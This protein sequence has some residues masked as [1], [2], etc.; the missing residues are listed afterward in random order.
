MLESWQREGI[1]TGQYIFDIG[2]EKNASKLRG[3]GN[4]IM[5]QEIKAAHIMRNGK[6]V[7]QRAISV[8]LHTLHESGI[9]TQEFMQEVEKTLNQATK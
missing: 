2:V 7:L 4:R 9:S 5:Q 8:C 1:T 6:T 3:L